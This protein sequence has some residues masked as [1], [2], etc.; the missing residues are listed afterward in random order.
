M[1]HDPIFT[2]Q[3]RLDVTPEQ[4]DAMSRYAMLYGQ[5]ERTL[6]AQMQAGT[7]SSV[8]SEFQCRFGIT[9]RQF[10]AVSIALKGKI[11]SIKE[12]RPGLISDLESKCARTRKTIARLEKKCPGS[13]KVHQKKRRLHTLEKRLENL[14]QDHTNGAVHMCFGSRKLFRAQFHLEANGYGS[15]DEW[16]SD[17]K[18]ARRREF[19]VI[20]SKDEKSGCQGCTATM[21][22]DGTLSLRLRL[23]DAVGKYT[24]FS[25]LRFAYGQEVIENALLVGQAISYRFVRDEK[26]WR[27]LASTGYKAP[28]VVTSRLAGAIGIDINADCLAVSE[29]DRF[30]NLMGSKVIGCVTYG[31]SKD[32]TRATIGDAVKIIKEQ[33]KDAG[34]PVVVEKLNFSKRKAELEKGSPRDSRMI[35][36]FAY[37][38]VHKTLRAACLRGGVEVI[39]VDPAYTSVIGAVNHASRHGISVHQGAAF[40]VAR[41]GLGLSERPAVAQ[42][43]APAR[44]GSHVTFSL[45]ARNRGKHVWSFWSATRSKLK[46][47]HAAH[48]RSGGLRTNPAPLRQNPAS[49]ATRVLPAKSRHANR[50]QHCSASVM[51]DIPF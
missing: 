38:E 48:I 44:N 1:N 2:Y 14:K 37:S 26:G 3:A 15:L 33:A 27:V 30:G 24:H 41:R 20:G 31:K 5:V 25:G 11:K 7:D 34:K 28:P 23:P 29:T 21:D 47:A 46:A 16:R 49:G 32:Q 12:R 42:G 17:W 10:N 9:A 8:K 51:D 39:S 6:F 43:V 4:D 36:S 13:N 45:P 22:A 19:F 35:S 18:E 50:S 40:V